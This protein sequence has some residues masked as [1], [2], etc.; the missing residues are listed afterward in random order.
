VQT[1]INEVIKHLKKSKSILF[2][3]GAGISADS[4]L[5]TYRGIGGLYN[6][7]LTEEGIPIEVALAGETLEKNPQ[8]T[9]KYLR[10][11]EEKCR[12]AKY[13]Q[14]HR[15]IA[16]MEEH[17]ERVCVL[18]QNIDG[19]HHD[20]GSSNVID[21]HGD[22]HKLLCAQ[23]GFRKRVKDYSNINIPPICPECENMMRPDVVFFGEMLPVDKVKTMMEQLDQGFDMYFSIG[24]TS[25]FHYISQPIYLASHLGR[26]TVEINPA[27]T[28]VSEIVDV[29]ISQTATKALK[30]IWEGLY[31]RIEEKLE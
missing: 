20:G 23:C 5:P 6:D 19:F 4:G 1:S 2:I 13:N 26:F 31:P 7:N 18:T 22:Y 3:T 17:F 28:A 21:I 15:I 30:Q 16:R 29:K 11:I 27:Q 24:T 25:V 10:H 8:I 12:D 9:W 14:A